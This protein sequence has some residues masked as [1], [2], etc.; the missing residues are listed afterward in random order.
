MILKAGKTLSP[1]PHVPANNQLLVLRDLGTPMKLAFAAHRNV[2][3]DQGVVQQRPV[4]VSFW[5][6]GLLIAAFAGGVPVDSVSEEASLGL[7]P[8]E[9]SIG[10]LEA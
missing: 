3:A 1:Y 4:L 6:L 9:A 8:L 5:A 10:S 7:Q 2:T